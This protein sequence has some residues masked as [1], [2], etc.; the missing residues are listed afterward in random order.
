LLGRKSRTPGSDIPR[1]FVYIS[2]RLVDD[3]YKRHIANKRGAKL[4]G[5][6]IAGNSIQG[7][8]GVP[9]LDNEYWLVHRVTDAIKGSTGSLLDHRRYIRVDAVRTTWASVPFMEE[10]A[11]VAWFEA[12]ADTSEGTVLIILCGSLRNLRGHI[13]TAHP[14]GWYPSTAEGL[15][16]IIRSFGHGNNDPRSVLRAATEEVPGL[17]TSAY[18]IGDIVAGNCKIGDENL[19]LLFEVF[20]VCDDISLS[21]RVFRR[22]YLGTPLW[23]A[24]RTPIKVTDATNEQN[25]HCGGRAASADR[26]EKSIGSAPSQT[27][28]HTPPATDN[29]ESSAFAITMTLYRGY[30]FGMSL[31]DLDPDAAMGTMFRDGFKA[32]SVP[33]VG[34]YLCALGPWSD[35]RSWTTAPTPTL[36]VRS[37]VYQADS[38]AQDNAEDGGHIMVHI[39]APWRQDIDREVFIKQFT[40]RG[41]QWLS[42]DPA[43]W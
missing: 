5:I 22:V 34:E 15:S 18:G 2:E 10:Q 31:D 32:V 1:E 24:S 19:D 11:R 12:E 37:V 33:R 7:Q 17:V 36:E 20:Y 42:A 38:P 29:S 35:R 21:G 3:L 43:D 28:V 26:V 27:T 16:Q 13:P 6:S 40:D 4:E 14:S 39:S 23:A 41:W 25:Q 30:E 9:Q 8:L